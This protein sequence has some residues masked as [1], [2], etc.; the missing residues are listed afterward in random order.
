MAFNW[1][2]G[3]TA[4]PCPSC[5]GTL[6]MTPLA[7]DTRASESTL[8]PSVQVH[9]QKVPSAFGPATRVTRLTWLPRGVKL[10]FELLAVDLMCARIQERLLQV[11][12][13]GLAMLQILGAA[14][15]SWKQRHKG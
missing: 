14:S 15:T 9:S 12:G 5:T 8:P 4:G 1:S 3:L 7:M 10:L 13:K 6:G 2:A 11:S